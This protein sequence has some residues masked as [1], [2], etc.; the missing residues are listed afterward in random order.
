MGDIPTKNLDLTA[1]WRLEP[2]DQSQGRG[3]ATTRRAKQYRKLVC[4]DS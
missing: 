3:F 2:S 1:R 4:G